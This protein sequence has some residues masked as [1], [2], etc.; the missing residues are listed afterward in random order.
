MDKVLNVSDSRYS[1]MFTC[2]AFSSEADSVSR[3]DSLLSE[4][5]AFKIFKEVEGTYEFNQHYKNRATPRI[6]MVIIPAR[7]PLSQVVGAIGIE[8]KA[9][10]INIG[11]PFSQC[12]DYSTAVF[13]LSGNT[14]VS[15][16]LD[17]VFL[18]PLKLPGGV[19][20]S[21]AT[22]NRVG[23][24]YEYA[25]PNYRALNFSF[26]SNTII[27][28]DFITKG[29]KIHESIKKMGVKKGSR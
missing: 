27:R 8:C 13:R 17:F 28:Y 1:G 3:L 21:I 18:W 20:S 23:G 7:K 11:K 26:G 22:Q 12:L 19:I 5:G 6:D 25:N 14:V 16:K 24:L 9:S 15:V 2:G 29:L 10:G 4:C